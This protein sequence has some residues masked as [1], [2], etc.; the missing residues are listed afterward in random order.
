MCHGFGVAC[1]VLRYN[2]TFAENQLE[3]YDIRSKHSSE[4]AN[5]KVS[6][7]KL[8]RNFPADLLDAIFIYL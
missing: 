1:L 2:P 7:W 4:A 5:R 6:D 3:R 8:S